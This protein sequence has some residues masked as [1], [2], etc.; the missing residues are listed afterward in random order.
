MML[1]STNK[2]M[3]HMSYMSHICKYAVYV[4]TTAFVV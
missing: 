3:S 1:L 2:Y 4:I